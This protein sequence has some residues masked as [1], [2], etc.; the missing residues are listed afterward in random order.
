MSNS[1]IYFDTLL[2][3]S[4]SFNVH[5]EK[6]WSKIELYWEVSC[7]FIVSIAPNV[8]LSYGQWNS[9]AGWSVLDL[10]SFSVC[11][12]KV[13]TRYHKIQIFTHLSL[14]WTYNTTS[15]FFFLPRKNEWKSDWIGI[16]SCPCQWPNLSLLV[17]GHKD[18]PSFR[19]P[20][21]L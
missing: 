11:I 12:V 20:V 8:E 18:I 17:L 16:C 19:T 2:K 7:F 14:L 13:I 6:K 10:L 15:E 9:S 5:T 4:E 1:F 21:I 3:K